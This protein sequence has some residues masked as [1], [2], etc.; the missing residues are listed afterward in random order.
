MIVLLLPDDVRVGDDEGGEDHN[1]DDGGV[2]EDDGRDGD[3]VDDHD[4]NADGNKTEDDII[5][6]HCEH[7]VVDTR[8]NDNESNDSEEGADAADEMM[9]LNRPGITTIIIRINARR[10]GEVAVGVVEVVAIPA[11]KMDNK[12]KFPILTSILF[13]I[14][15]VFHCRD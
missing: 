7:E 4:D 5:S 3:Y 6:N 12:S 11:I 1:E 9:M 14:D 8:D 13:V 15:A 10:R 2:T